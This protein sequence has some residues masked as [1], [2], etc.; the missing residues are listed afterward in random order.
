MSTVARQ[1]RSVEWLQ[2]QISWQRFRAAQ[3]P[4]DA[5]LFQLVETSLNDVL[6]ICERHGCDTAGELLARGPVPYRG[7]DLSTVRIPEGRTTRLAEQLDAEAS[8]YLDLG[9][10]LALLVAWSI[11][12]HS[13]GAEYHHA[14]NVA[15]YLESE[16]YEAAYVNAMDDVLGCASLENPLW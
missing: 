14:D 2:T 5:P 15:E 1:L 12:W 13:E 4:V 6:I 11:L 8:Y 10:E 7:L 3:C 9:T 16:E